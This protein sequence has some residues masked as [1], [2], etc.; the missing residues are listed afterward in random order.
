MCGLMHESSVAVL[1]PKITSASPPV[2]VPTANG[3]NG[4]SRRHAP[5]LLAANTN[6]GATFKMTEFCA[7]EPSSVIVITKE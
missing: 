5:P 4:D 3:R 1:V 6:Y 7:T 2:L